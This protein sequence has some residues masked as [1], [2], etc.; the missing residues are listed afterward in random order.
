MLV[1]K[2]PN[3]AVRDKIGPKVHGAEWFHTFMTLLILELNSNHDCV[4]DLIELILSYELCVNLSF[5]VYA[6]QDS[7][8]NN[9]RFVEEKFKS[10]LSV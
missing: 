6:G 4:Y 1:R 2:S 8:V 9:F 3:L 5:D 7:E 10:D